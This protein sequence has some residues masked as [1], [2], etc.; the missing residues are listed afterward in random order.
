LYC[1]LTYLN[2]NTQRRWFFAAYSTTI[3]S[4]ISFFPAFYWL[5][6]GDISE[7]NFTTGL[8]IFVQNYL[9]IEFLVLGIFFPSQCPLLE[10]WIHHPVFIALFQF[11][12]AGNYTGLLRPFFILEVPTAI[13]SIGKFYPPYRN[14]LAFGIS[15]ATLRVAWPFYVISRSTYI[16]EWAY[17]PFV[18]MQAAHCYWFA[19]WFNKFM[20]NNTN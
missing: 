7:N 12:L 11:I 14:D 1:T 9:S 18:L 6:T 16:P 8:T 4:I 2:T 20:K 13:R 19:I 3:I 17:V 5:V 15:F 10:F